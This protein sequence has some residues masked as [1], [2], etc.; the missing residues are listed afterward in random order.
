MN[1]IEKN[2][3]IRFIDE[4]YQTQEAKIIDW[5][6]TI[7]DIKEYI[8]E[9]NSKGEE[10]ISIKPRNSLLMKK[11]QKWGEEEGLEVK[12]EVLMGGPILILLWGY[13]PAFIGSTDI[14]ILEDGTVVP[15]G[16]L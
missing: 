7:E 2:K 8:R 5:S 16:K 9:T 15:R 12:E 10:Y 1:Q 11:L 14:T 3:P 6:K 13:A 4:I